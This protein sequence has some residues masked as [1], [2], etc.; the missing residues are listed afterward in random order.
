MSVNLNV[1]TRSDTVRRTFK[2]KRTSNTQ[3]VHEPW[4]ALTQGTRLGRF[5]TLAAQKSTSEE[6]FRGQGPFIEFRI[7][8]IGRQATSGIANID[9]YICGGLGHWRELDVLIGKIHIARG[10]LWDVDKGERVITIKK[11]CLAFTNLKK[12]CE[13]TIRDIDHPKPWGLRLITVKEGKVLI[14]P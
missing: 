2:F 14:T 8:K 5:A 10:G 12:D 6:C 1:F 4:G 3:L 9:D 13:P 11:A 7:E